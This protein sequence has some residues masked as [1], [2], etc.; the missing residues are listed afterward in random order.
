M[1]SHGAAAG[2]LQVPKM[3]ASVNC[4]AIE[5]S[6][7]RRATVDTSGQVALDYVLVHEMVGVSA[8]SLRLGAALDQTELSSAIDAVSAA[9]GTASFLPAPSRRCCDSIVHNRLDD[10]RF[11]YD[12]LCRKPRQCHRKG[13][14]EAEAE[15]TRNRKGEGLCHRGQN[16]Y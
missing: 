8:M 14:S 3:T 16:T 13:A 7:Q 11:R 6:H 9:N 12:G 4:H 5:L 1:V 2:L 10:R 15:T